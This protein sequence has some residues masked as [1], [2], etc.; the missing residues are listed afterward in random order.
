MIYLAFLRGDIVIMRY[1]MTKWDVLEE[2]EMES[3]QSNEKS[4]QKFFDLVNSRIKN[5]ID[6]TG[7]CYLMYYLR[8]YWNDYDQYQYP[9]PLNQIKEQSEQ[10]EQ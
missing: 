9:Y 5:R 3:E 10:S 2:L 8:R 4:E 1:E 6:H 7:N